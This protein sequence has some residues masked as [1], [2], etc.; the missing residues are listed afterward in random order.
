V[1]LRKNHRTELIEPMLRARGNNAAD[2][3]HDSATP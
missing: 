1:P 2:A 3:T